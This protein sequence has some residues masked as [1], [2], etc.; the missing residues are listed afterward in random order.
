[1]QFIF[2]KSYYLFKYIPKHSRPR[3]IHGQFFGEVEMCLNTYYMISTLFQ[4]FKYIDQLT[5]YQ[6]MFYTKLQTMDSI[7]SP[8]A[9]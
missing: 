6:T 2:G 1:M 4:P 9:D 5:Y 7:A 3:N 8:D